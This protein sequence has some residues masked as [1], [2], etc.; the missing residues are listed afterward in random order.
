MT[1]RE[2]MLVHPTRRSDCFRVL[3]IDGGGMR[4]LYSAAYLAALA[5]NA[6]ARRKTADLDLGRAFD[7]L[8]GTSTGGIIAC[9]LAAGLPLTKVVDLYQTHGKEIFAVKMPNGLGFDFVRQLFRRPKYLA[10]G[11]AAL[12]RILHAHFGDLT[13]RE[14][15]ERR[16]VAVAIPA[17]EMSRH[18]SWVF[19]TSHLGGH[20]D[21]GFRLVDVCLATTAAPLYRSMARLTTPMMPG[22]HHVFVDG[23]LWANNPVLVA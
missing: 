5:A 2:A 14:V 9:A 4:G 18:R 3:C 13:L 15:Y 11:D 17:V 16:Q 20:R 10:S 1:Q 8:V 21:D 12:E 22:N 23:G 6:A 7:L 19:K